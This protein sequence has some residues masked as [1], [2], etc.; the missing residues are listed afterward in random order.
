MTMLETAPTTLMVAVG[1]SRQL[2]LSQIQI[3][4]VRSLW[5]YQ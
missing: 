2:G 3:A 4:R 1:R 5:Q